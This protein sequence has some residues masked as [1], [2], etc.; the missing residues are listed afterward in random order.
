MATTRVD[1]GQSES[2]KSF[3]LKGGAVVSHF[4][5]EG[6]LRTGNISEDPDGLVCGSGNAGST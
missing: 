1:S 4:A 5:L 6:Q 2:T 3:H